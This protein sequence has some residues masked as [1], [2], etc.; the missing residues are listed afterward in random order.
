MRRYFRRL[1]RSIRKL[2]GAQR[3]S[4][5]RHLMTFAGGILATSGIITS[6]LYMEL[7][8]AILGILGV[9]WGISDKIQDD[10]GDAG[11]N[12]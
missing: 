7:S 5:L 6:E 10:L 1:A 11:D 9:F 12:E 4:I 8:G 3:L 2:S